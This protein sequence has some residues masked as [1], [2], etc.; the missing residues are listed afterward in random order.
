MVIRSGLRAALLDSV[1]CVGEGVR[2]SRSV[3][4]RRDLAR[5]S[6]RRG[7]ATSRRTTKTCCRFYSPDEFRARNEARIVEQ[8]GRLKHVEISSF[9]REIIAKVTE[10]RGLSGVRLLHPSTMYRLF[11]HF[12]FQRVPVTL[13]EAF[14]SFGPLPPVELGDLRGR[15][16]RAVRGSEV[17]RQHRACRTRRRITRS[18]RRTSK[19]SRG[20]S[21]SC[22]S[23]PATRFDDHEDMAK[24]DRGRIHTIDHLMTPATNLDV[25]TRI[26]AAAEALRRHLRRASPTS[27]RSAART[28]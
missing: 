27:R 2:Q 25:Q 1:P 19:S 21:M 8:R 7:I 4:A 11:D 20:T 24:A 28:R 9:D 23:T 10:K 12:W 22:C 5:R 3:A 18:S 15:S 17:L 6:A 26:I 13:V 14:T 16:S